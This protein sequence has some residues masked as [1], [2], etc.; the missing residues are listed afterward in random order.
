MVTFL[1]TSS[2]VKLY[3]KEADSE[4][5]VQTLLS[6]APT[7]YLCELSKV[8][9]ASASWKKVRMGDIN[10]AMCEAVLSLF[11][12]DFVKY[13]WIALDHT[14]L[15]MA[16]HFFQKYGSTSLRALDAL[17]LSAALSI[18]ANAEVFLTNDDLL[19]ALFEKEGLQTSF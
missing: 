14:L 12:K 16:R 15:E 8:E 18:K 13:R 6:N 9:F 1:D 3:Y 4:T 17:Q 10:Q 7:I 19:R 11:E 2:L 5:F